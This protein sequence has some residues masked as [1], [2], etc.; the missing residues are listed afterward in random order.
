[1]FDLKKSE[2]SVEWTSVWNVIKI[3]GAWHTLFIMLRYQWRH[4]T[5]VFLKIIENFLQSEN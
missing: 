1:M 2:I 3:D 5:I 4:I